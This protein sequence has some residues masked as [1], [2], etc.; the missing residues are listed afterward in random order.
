MCN[1][2]VMLQHHLRLKMAGLAIL[3]LWAVGCTASADRSADRVHGLHTWQLG[4]LVD[5]AGHARSLTL[6]SP[7]QDQLVASQPWLSQG[8]SWYAG[9]LDEGPMVLAGLRSAIVSRSVTVTRDGFSSSRGRV[10]DNF[11]TRSTT[12]RAV[13]TIR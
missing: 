6:D 8:S 10:F 5:E 12:T 9:R 3:A 4:P 1:L 7:T 13:E 11:R 2:L